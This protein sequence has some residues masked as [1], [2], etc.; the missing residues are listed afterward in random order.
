MS[1]LSKRRTIKV[2][3]TDTGQ[4]V[5]IPLRN[6]CK[7]TEA[8]QPDNSSTRS[9]VYVKGYSGGSGVM[10]TVDEIEAQIED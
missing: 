4:K 9:Y 8:K 5:L 10:E 2:T 1:M 3:F 7:V 6:V